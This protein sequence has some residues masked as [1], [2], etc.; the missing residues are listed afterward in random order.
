LNKVI[1]LPSGSESKLNLTLVQ[2]IAKGEKM[3]FLM[4][5]SVELGVN[6]II[7]VFTQHCGK[8]KPL[9]T[10]CCKKSLKL[11]GASTFGITERPDCSQ[12]PPKYAQETKLPIKQNP[13]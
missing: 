4:Q 10:D 11:I 2:G 1:F 7:P 6:R 13:N 5:K 9:T 12:L 8:T 3:D